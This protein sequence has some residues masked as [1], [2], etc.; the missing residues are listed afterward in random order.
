MNAS[1]WKID[2]V[3][4]LLFMVAL[5]GLALVVLAP[6]A[7]AANSTNVAYVT[8][9]GAGLSEHQSRQ[10]ARQQRGEIDNTETRQRLHNLLE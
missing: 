2:R 9:F 1:A 8:D 10:W 7:H 4:R 5:L 6:K 3:T